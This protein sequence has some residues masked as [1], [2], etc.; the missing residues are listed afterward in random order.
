[1]VADL[2]A[3]IKTSISNSEVPKRVYLPNGDISLVTHVGSYNVFGQDTITNVFHL[4]QFK[5]NLL[6]VSKLTKEQHRLVVFYP[7]LCISGSLLWE[8]EGDW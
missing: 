4:P 8:G 5:F 7:D 3:L 6:S 1:M 2:S